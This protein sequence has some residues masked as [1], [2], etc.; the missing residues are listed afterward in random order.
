ME[1]SVKSIE[2]IDVEAVKK[3]VFANI[4][5]VVYFGNISVGEDNKV[6]I[7]DSIVTNSSSLKDV[8][9]Q[10][11]SAKNKGELCNPVVG[12]QIA[13]NIE[14]MNESQLL[15]VDA[16]LSSINIRLKYAFVDIA[17]TIIAGQ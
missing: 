1:K 11:L 15:E 14:K 8:I 7:K 4:N 12:G 3:L 10:Y 6:E 2:V 9:K 13:F 5:G 17:N 16:L